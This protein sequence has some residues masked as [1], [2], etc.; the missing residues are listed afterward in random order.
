VSTALVVS[1][2]VVVEEPLSVDA[3]VKAMTDAGTEMFRH[4]LG[5]T[6]SMNPTSDEPVET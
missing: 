4:G 5:I 3:V 6:L 1:L 2:T